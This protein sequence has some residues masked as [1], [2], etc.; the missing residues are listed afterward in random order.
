MFSFCF[1]GL[2]DT[3]LLNK[4]EEIGSKTTLWVIVEH[5]LLGKKIRIVVSGYGVQD[6]ERCEIMLD[7]L[8]AL[9]LRRA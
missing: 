4:G 5:S 8:N 2:V 7:R 3:L 6:R 9:R 1:N